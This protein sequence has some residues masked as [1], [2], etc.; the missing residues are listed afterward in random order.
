M[1]SIRFGITL[2]KPPVA[3]RTYSTD[4]SFVAE[5]EFLSIAEAWDWK[6]EWVRKNPTPKDH[7]VI[8]M[9]TERGKAEVIL[10]RDQQHDRAYL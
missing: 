4:D 9:C 7:V 6:A 8:L 5:A 2:I 3:R 1:K 10:A